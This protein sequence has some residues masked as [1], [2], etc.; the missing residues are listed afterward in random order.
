MKS[1]QNTLY[2]NGYVPRSYPI[3]LTGAPEIG[4]PGY[5]RPKPGRPGLDTNPLKWVST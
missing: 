1:T 2:G 5:S 4:I 3:F